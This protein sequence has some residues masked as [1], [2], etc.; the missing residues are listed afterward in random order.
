MLHKVWRFFYLPLRI[1]PLKKSTIPYAHISFKNHFETLLKWLPWCSV[2]REIYIIN[3]LALNANWHFKKEQKNMNVLACAS[4]SVEL[5]TF[6]LDWNFRCFIYFFSAQSSKD[7]HYTLHKTEVYE[8]QKILT[9]LCCCY[10]TEL[11]V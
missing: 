4:S 1:Q 3:S 6:L 11:Q 9:L 8:F 5:R 2:N 10:S 7:L